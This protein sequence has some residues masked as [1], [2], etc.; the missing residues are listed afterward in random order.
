MHEA[1][2]DA[3]TLLD[4]GVA[5]V[6]LPG[7]PESGDLHLVRT[8]GGGVLV[9]VVDGVGHGAEAAT[10]A[11]LAIAALARHA[12]ESPP[13]LLERT[14]QALQVTLGGVMSLAF[15]MLTDS[16]FTS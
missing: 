13:P 12:H 7:E 4:W 5:A 10:A 11:R 16:S 3:A 8:V 6:A 2:A 9:A 14:H 1:P 15:M